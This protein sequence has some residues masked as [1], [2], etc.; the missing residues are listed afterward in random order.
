MNKLLMLQIALANLVASEDARIVGMNWQIALESG[1]I[2]FVEPSDEGFVSQIFH[3]ENPYRV[4]PIYKEYYE[5]RQALIS[6]SQL[7]NLIN[8][9][10]EDEG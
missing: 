3:P 5:D 2:L 4:P 7:Q 10:D 8:E 6:V 9:V 1:D